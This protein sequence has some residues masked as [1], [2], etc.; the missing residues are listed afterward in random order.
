MD[1]RV[2]SCAAPLI[3][4]GWVRDASAHNGQSG[5]FQNLRNLELN[6]RAHVVVASVL[7]IRGVQVEASPCGESTSIANKYYARRARVRRTCA[8]I[9]IV[10]LTFDS[11]ATR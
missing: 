5:S 2:R 1:T 11:C 8:K 4:H 3:Q 6:V 7:R 9:P 10:I